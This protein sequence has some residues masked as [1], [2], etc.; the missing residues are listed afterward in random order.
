MKF[1]QEDA[2][3]SKSLSV[4][5]IWCTKAINL[6]IIIIIIIIEAIYRAQDRTKATSALLFFYNP[7]VE[8]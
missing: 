8:K 5:G 2:I 6:I 1:S 4:E 7:K 3:W